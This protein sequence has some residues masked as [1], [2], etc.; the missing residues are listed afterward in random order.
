[1]YAKMFDESVVK[2]NNDKEESLASNIVIITPYKEFGE[3]QARWSDSNLLKKQ[4]AKAC[5]IGSYLNI[6]DT[7]VYNR[8]VF[9]HNKKRRKNGK[10]KFAN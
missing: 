4:G 3:G 8:R 9:M 2:I 5:T 7:P 1:M 10:D 6:E